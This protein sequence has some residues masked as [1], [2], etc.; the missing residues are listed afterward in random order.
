VNQ[1]NAGNSVWDVLFDKFV[2]EAGATLSFDPRIPSF[3][4]SLDVDLLFDTELRLMLTGQLVLLTA[5]KF[6]VKIFG[7][8]SDVGE[9]VLTLLALM[10]I[11]RFRTMPSE[12]SRSSW[13]IGIARVAYQ[14]RRQP[15]CA[16]RFS[17]RYHRC[18][19]ATV[20]IFRCGLGHGK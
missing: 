5:V 7:D 8:F 18:D 4:V 12:S 14:R 9:G 19:A 20:V 13:R 17:G 6:P 11:R 10:D 2:I 15:R 16:H 1:L 3:L